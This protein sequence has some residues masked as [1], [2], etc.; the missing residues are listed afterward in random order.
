MWW[1]RSKRVKPVD[2]SAFGMGDALLFVTH[3]HS[4]QYKIRGRTWVDLPVLA[5]FGEGEGDGGT[6]DYDLPFGALLLEE[7][8]LLYSCGVEG[9]VWA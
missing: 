3:P 8:R 6:C 9:D 1:R 4:C 7:G 2:V 5:E